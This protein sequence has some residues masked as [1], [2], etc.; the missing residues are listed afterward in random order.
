MRRHAQHLHDFTTAE[1]ASSSLLYPIANFEGI[2]SC[3]QT[4]P[5]LDVV[6]SRE[7]AER[8]RCASP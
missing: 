7:G 5:G 6:T 2:L 8:L 1:T 3:A 4:T